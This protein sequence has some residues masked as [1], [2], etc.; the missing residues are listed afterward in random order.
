MD[1]IDEIPAKQDYA[2]RPQSSE[3]KKRLNPDEETVPSYRIQLNLSEEQEK[4]LTE[5]FTMEFDALVAERKDLDLEAKWKERDAQYD[6]EMEG[7][8][9]IPFNL[10]VHQSKI[11]VDAIKRAVKEAFLDGDP[12]LDIS[13]R[14]ESSRKDGYQ[15]AKKQTQFLDYTL[16]EECLID[17]PFDQIIAC[18]AKK[19]V[20]IG[21]LSW[22]YRMEK[23]RREEKYEGKNIPSEIAPDGRILVK[24]E[25]LEQF[26]KAYPDSMEK[27]KGYVKRLLEEKTIDIVVNYNDTVENNADLTDVAIEDFFVKNSTKYNKGLRTAHLI[28]ERQNYTYWDLK[29][30]Q[31]AKEFKNIEALFNSSKEEGKT[32]LADGYQTEEYKVIEATMYFS[33]NDGDEEVK[34]KA[35]FGEE[36][37]CFLGAI[38]Y[39]YYAF[40]TDYIGFW[41]ELNKRGFYGDALSVM[42]NLRDSNLAQN[43]LLNLMLYGLYLRNTITPIA[44]EGSDV[45]SM[46]Q[47]K[48]WTAGMPL[49]VDELTDDVNKGV[50]FIQW[51]SIDMNSYMALNELLRRGDSDVTKVSDLTSGRESVI[52][53]NAPAS[54]TLALLEQSGLGIKEYIRTLLPSF[55]IMCTMILQ[56]YYQ[57]S[58]EGRKYKVRRKAEGVTG[59]DPFESISRDEMIVKT[60]VQAR[61]ASFVFNKVSEKQEALAAMQTVNASPYLVSQPEVLFESIKIFLD[62]MGQRWTNLS[63]KI[64]D[65]SKFK[66]RQMQVAMQALQ[67]LMQQAQQKQQVTGVQAEMPQPEEMAGAV[68]KA[69]EEDFNP[70]LKAEREKAMAKK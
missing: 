4:R 59:S 60:N 37:K 50:G 1:K 43:V 51:P 66:E 34:I 39:P 15:I 38:L 58:Q 16:D 7:N 10:H 70:Q 47:D 6:G 29:K 32:E 52:D 19:F 56:I 11:K 67:A 20:G 9:L 55:N 26:M 42:Y 54:K 68:T 13:P 46:F 62:T 2:I 63:D 31:D 24:N 3:E 61:A 33:V 25:G 21:K 22:A 65:P 18:S 45:A 36:K 64:L 44:K 40:D 30:K 53:P 5:Q 8:K 57:M 27:Y 12:R 14:P 48:T 23:R 17:E 28:G 41:L 69:Q 49:I 35:W